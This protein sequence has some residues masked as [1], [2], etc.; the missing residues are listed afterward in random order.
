[1]NILVTQKHLTN[2][3]IGKEEYVQLLSELCYRMPYGVKVQTNDGEVEE[4]SPMGLQRAMSTSVAVTKPYLFPLSSMTEE[5]YEEFA[6]V[7]NYNN[8]YGFEHTKRGYFSLK[9]D[10]EVSDLQNILNLFY[11]H[12]LDFN[13]F[14]EKGLA[15]DATNLN[16]Y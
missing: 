16:I 6:K 8:V 3:L 11:K 2:S 1:M 12:H 15:L 7:C 4:L 5:Q 14:I 10:I 13:C 9:Q